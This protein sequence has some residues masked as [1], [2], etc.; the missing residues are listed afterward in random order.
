MSQDKHYETEQQDKIPMHQRI[1]YGFG[2]MVN[3]LLADAMGKM[4]QVLTLGLGMSPALV[5][6]LGSLPRVMDALTDPLMGYIS[7]N[8]KT[9]WG[10]RRPYIF[11]GAIMVGI[12]YALI[13]QLPEG[14]SDTFYFWVFL[15]G[16]CLF[17]LAYTVFATPWVALGYELTP[18]YHERTRVMGTTHFMGYAVYMVTPYFMSFMQSDAFDNLMDGAATLALIVG[19]FAIFVGVLPALFLKERI[20]AP[21]ELST[22]EKKSLSAGDFFRG[23]AATVKFKPFLLL[24]GATFLVFNGFIMVSNFQLY[25]I[26]YY[27]F[28]GDQTQGFAYAGH[29]GTL[30][31]AS[32]FFAIAAV[33]WLATKIGKRRAF[34]W[35]LGIS[36]V[37]YGIRYFFYVPESPWL[38]FLPVPLTA[39]GL[40]P[41]FAMMGSMVADVVDLD[42]LE[43]GERR[44]GMFG[45]I[46]W[47]VV[48]MGMAAAILAGGILLSGS[49]FDVELGGN[50]SE[51]ALLWMRIF[52]AF[53]PMIFTLMAIYLVYLFPITEERAHEIREE[54]EARRGKLN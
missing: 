42:E 36:A 23:F 35:A 17:F 50:Q 15:V 13:W 30:S 10:R 45:S 26:T 20:S 12:I 5:G 21:K 33:S 29:A 46:F 49:G 44:E 37:G 52:D 40:G 31:A 16:S 2:G 28:D 3:N 32:T 34:F 48:K 18:D 14:Q 9:R 6:L 51:T 1:I 19:A 39:F 38:M 41:L 8:T 25:V 22:E 27:V 24:C 4:M 7:D 11:A 54:L 53:L 47:W 43:R